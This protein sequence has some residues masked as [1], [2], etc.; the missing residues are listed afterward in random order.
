[1]CASG[2]AEFRAGNGSQFRPGWVEEHAFQFYEVPHRNRLELAGRFKMLLFGWHDHPSL[3]ET[4]M[5]C[6]TTLPRALRRASV[7]IP[8]VAEA[9]M[10]ALRPR[11]GA[12]VVLPWP[13]G[14]VDHRK[15]RECWRLVRRDRQA[16]AEALTVL[17]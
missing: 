9:R 4:L 16:R 1:M 14:C 5:G 7:V 8:R 15:A 3:S 2:C 17:R 6:E 13:R 11:P 10:V 12:R